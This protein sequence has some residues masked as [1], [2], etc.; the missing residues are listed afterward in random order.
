MPSFSFSAGRRAALGLGLWAALVTTGAQAADYL[1][2]AALAEQLVAN[3]APEKN[4]YDSDP[5]IVTWAGLNGATQYENRSTCS[6]FVTR[7]I[8]TAYGFSDAAY[9]TRTG[10]TSPSSARYYDLTVAQSGFLNITRVTDIRRNDI[11]AMKYLPCAN[12]S[13]SGHTM[14]AL[15]TPVRR[16]VDTAPLVPGTVQYEV[17]V[18]DS[19]ASEHHA[20]DSTG[21]LYADTRGDDGNAG[22]GGAGIGSFRLYADAVTGALVG[23]TWSMSSGSDYYNNAGCR[24]IAVG[25]MQ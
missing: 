13:S 10:S 25:R 7:V 21:K 8:K 1:N 2:H 9:K 22:R 18:V 17:Q 5:T 12:K 11:V 16:A 23:Y 14:I 24:L 3:V 20:T 19:S 15:S 4:V 6:P